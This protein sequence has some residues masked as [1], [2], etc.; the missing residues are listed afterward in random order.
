MRLLLMRHAPAQAGADEDPDRPLLPG[1]RLQLQQPP[2][3]MQALLADVGLIVTSPWTRARDTACA[4]LPF[5]C[6]GAG[7]QNSDAL[8]P[9]ASLVDALA[10][11]ENALCEDTTLLAIGHQPLL[12]RLVALLC[13]GPQATPLLP[14]PGE[15]AVIEL[16]WPAAGLGTLLGWQRL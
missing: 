5:C 11:L 12:G 2:A 16:D 10:L 15:M 7:L 6:A 1:A 9:D 8:L 13:E 4:L 3:P 14:A